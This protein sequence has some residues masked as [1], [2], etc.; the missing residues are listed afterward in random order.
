M[1]R[2]RRKIESSSELVQEIL[3][4][5]ADIVESFE[6]SPRRQLVVGGL[7]DTAKIAQQLLAVDVPGHGQNGLD[8]DEATQAP[9]EE[10]NTHGNA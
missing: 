8:F 3:T 1:A 10:A 9:T 6:D 2:R 7:L 5:A 4:F